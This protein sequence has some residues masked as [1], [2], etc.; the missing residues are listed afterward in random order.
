[1]ADN[2]NM[3]RAFASIRNAVNKKK[4]EDEATVE[5]PKD[6]EEEAKKKR[7][8][9]LRNSFGIGGSAAKMGVRG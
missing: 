1:M 9:E 7:W 3:S 2:S 6:A 5:Q 8:Q 4:P